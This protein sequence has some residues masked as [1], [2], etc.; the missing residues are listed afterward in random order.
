MSRL[1]LV[2][3][4]GFLGSAARYWLAGQVHSWTGAAFPAGT[5]VVNGLGSF[6]LGMVM[7]LGLERG[8]ITP[9]LRLFLAVG[10]CG[11]FTTMS[12]FSYETLALLQEGSLATALAN[13]AGTLALCIVAV[14]L[15]AA[16]GRLV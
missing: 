15:G 10:L 5:L 6:V 8:L 3:L 2:G 1:V 12:T 4:G 11:G 9:N 14:W 13:V 7:A 16:A